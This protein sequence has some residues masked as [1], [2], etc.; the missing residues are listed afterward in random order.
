MEEDWDYFFFRWGEYKSMVNLGNKEKEHLG[1]SLGDIVISNVYGRLGKVK[2]EAL[3]VGELL[4]EVKQLVV[5]S[6]NKLVHRLKL[7]TMTQDGEEPIAAFETRLKP[8]ARIGKFQVECPGCQQKVDYTDQ[9]VLFNLI[10]GLA[11]EEVKKKVLATPE[12]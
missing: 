3:S 8:V 7:G 9:M 2:Y 1:A 10:R 12:V 11:D 5:R 4:K 6:R